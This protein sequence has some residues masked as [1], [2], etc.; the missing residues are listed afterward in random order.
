MLFVTHRNRNGQSQCPLLPQLLPLSRGFVVPRL[1][2]EPKVKRANGNRRM[3][4]V[5]LA[6]AVAVAW[7]SGPCLASGAPPDH[8]PAVGSFRL[9]PAPSRLGAYHNVSLNS[10]G[11]ALLYTADDDEWPYHM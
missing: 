9:A 10:W 11:G 6:A 1:V 3:L 2:P 4:K 8:G 5:V 7:R